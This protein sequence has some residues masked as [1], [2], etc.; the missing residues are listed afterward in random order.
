[1]R[2]T[3]YFVTE[4][5]FPGR[6]RNPCP[7]RPV[8]SYN[9]NFLYIPPESSRRVTRLSMADICPLETCG[10]LSVFFPALQSSS[11]QDVPDS[12]SALSRTARSVFSHL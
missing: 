12:L 3:I 9:G 4:A 6:E 2:H 11:Q 5:P 10:V 8:L 7:S 1:M